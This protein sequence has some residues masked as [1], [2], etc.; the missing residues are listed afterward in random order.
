[1]NADEPDRNGRFRPLAG[2][3]MRVVFAVCG[4]CALL[5]ASLQGWQ[6]WNDTEQAN[7]VAVAEVTTSRLPLLTAALWDIDSP[8]VQ[9]LVSEIA[10]HPQI[11]SVRL[12]TAG[13]QSFAAGDPSV[14]AQGDV[15]LAVP[16]PQSGRPLGQLS[17]VFDTS[18]LGRQLVAALLRTF[19]GIAML[20][21]LTGLVLWR[22]LRRELSDPLRRVAEYAREL[23]PGVQSVPLSLDRTPR[24]WTDDLDVVADA[25]QVLQR[26]LQHYAAER[27]EA[28]Q[29]LARERDQLDDAVRQRTADLRRLNESLAWLTQLS[30]R[31]INLPLERYPDA[32]RGALTDAA[33]MLGAEACALAERGAKGQWEWRF[34]GGPMR[35]RLEEGTALPAL[36]CEHAVPQAA[37]HDGGSDTLSQRVGATVRLLCLREEQ[38]MGQ[39]LASVGTLRPEVRREELALIGESLFGALSRWRSLLELDRVRQQLLQQS[40][41]DPLTGLANRR[42]FEERKLEAL[43]RMRG[44]GGAF[45]LLML[46]LDHFKAYNDTYGHGAGDE[47]LARVA[48]C[49]RSVFQ[50]ASDCIARIGG[51]EFVVLL[52]GVGASQALR[53]GE[54][55]REALARLEIPHAAS[56]LGF[57]SASIGTATLDRCT[58]HTAD[59]ELERLMQ[60]ADDALY[61]AKAAG[62]NAVV[63]RRVEALAPEP[64][65]V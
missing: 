25:F 21:S 49:L 65:S 48:H 16:H 15:V 10:R 50:R 59:A 28:Q 38:A 27:D 56:P 8:T 57:V 63:V 32:L 9:R 4:G 11:R 47:C 40:R 53:V 51:E 19:I 55:A 33:V 52:P 1:V 20:A 36:P 54:R 62:R 61:E 41:S 43:R 64:G 45:T 6:V 44:Q 2:R 39:V 42:A 5:V 60:A 58:P 37:G 13:G 31:L 14:P 7:R 12:V 23:K 17:I 18:Y 46:D 35:D 3:L 29:T 26:G 24:P 30:A 22:F 34:V